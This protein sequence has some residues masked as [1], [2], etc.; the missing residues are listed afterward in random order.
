VLLLAVQLPLN[1][2]SSWPYAHEIRYHYVAPIL[3]FVFLAVIEAL[4][5]RPAGG[6]SRRLG[7]ALLAAGTLAG[8]GLFASPWLY[9]TGHWRGLARDAVE[10]RDTAALLARIPGPASVSA[11][12]RFLPHLARRRELFMFPDLGPGAAPDAVVVDLAEVEK[13]E[14]DR[15]A[16]RRIG[17][18]CVEAERTAG[19]TALFW[20]GDVPVPRPIL[21]PS[22]PPPAPGG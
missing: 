16:F 20:C 15:E 11:Q 7:L 3:P 4:A 1:M 2:V 18:S 14:S 12:Y 8:Q 22:A 17:P 10:R 6:R 13:N 21:P 9:S 5:A 19:G